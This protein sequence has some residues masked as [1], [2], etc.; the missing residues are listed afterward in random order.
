[1]PRIRKGERQGIYELR[2][3]TSMLY[4]HSDLPLTILIQT[5]LVLYEFKDQMYVEN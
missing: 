5:S 4:I 3:Y 2:G 1:M